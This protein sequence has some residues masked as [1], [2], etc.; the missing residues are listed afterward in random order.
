MAKF[1]VTIGYDQ[2]YYFDINGE[3]A[4]WDWK[5]GGFVV[6]PVGDLFESGDVRVFECDVPEDMLENTVA[7][8]EYLSRKLDELSNEKCGYTYGAFV[9]FLPQ[10]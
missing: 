3:Y 6:A 8:H 9:A 5:T 7:T 1:R 10:E 2:N 4:W